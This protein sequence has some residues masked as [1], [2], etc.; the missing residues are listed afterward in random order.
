[1]L[2]FEELA[3]HPMPSPGTTAAKTFP[4]PA[5][6]AG[7]PNTVAM[8][9]F[10]DAPLWPDPTVAANDALGNP[11][12]TM[13]DTCLP[14]VIPTGGV[15]EGRPPGSNFAHQRWNE[16]PPRFYV[17]TAV[18]G[19]RRNSGRLD[20]VQ[21]HGYA[22]GEF[23]PVV[24]GLENQTGL[25][26]NTVVAPG[27]DETTE[28]IE[29]RL[30][31]LLPIQS[32]L[33]VWTFSDGTLPPKLMRVRQ[34]LPLL[35]RNYNALP[36]ATNANA[37]FGEH[38]LST[39]QHNGHNPGESDGFTGAYFF[40]G[41]FYDYRW[42]MQLAGHD[43][44]NTAA[45][46]PRASI[47]C[48]PG[49]TL[50]IE[51]T[52]KTCNTDTLTINIPGDWHE[53][54]STHWF[55][56]HMIDSTAENVYKGIAGM[57]NIYTGIDRGT[58]GFLCNYD[59]PANINLCF[60]SGTALDWG[61][62]DYDVDLLVAD[63]ALDA[64]GQLTFP[65]LNADGFLGDVMAVNWLYKPYFDVRARRYRFR[66]L[67]G[68][69]ARF[70]KIAIVRE[71]DDATSGN[72]P[73]PAGS[74]RS[75]SRV[76]FHMIANDGNIMEHAV[77]FPN[78]ESQDLPV[79]AN[80]ERHDIIVDFREFPAGTKLYLVNTL[81]FDNGRGPKAV[82]PLADILN[83][84]FA[85]AID[86]NNKWTED[87]AVGKFLEFR[88]QPYSGT[89]LSMNPVDYEVGKKMMIPLVRHTNTELAAAIHRTFEFGRSGGTDEKPWTIRTDDGSGLTAD[90]GRVA[91]APEGGAI[92]IWHIINGGNGWAH[93]I[94]IHFEEGQYLL[95]S[96]SSSGMPGN[97]RLPPLWEIGARKDLYVVADLGDPATGG[98][99]LPDVSRSI[100]VAIRF[101]EFMGT[102]VEHCHNTVHED[103]AML[104]RWDNEHPGQTVRIPTP[105]PTW[106]GVSYIATQQLATIKTGN[107]AVAAASDLDSDDVLD[108]AD[109]CVMAANP[110]QQDTGDGGDGVGDA[111]DNCI[112]VA[113]A[114][115]RDTDSDG[116]GN[117]CDADFNQNGVVDST[118]LSDLKTALR[119]TAPDQDLN[120]NGVVDSTDYSIA[121]GYLRQP[122]GPS[123]CGTLSP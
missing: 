92:E 49:E 29:P 37:G 116:Y 105:I 108:S 12:A 32:A 115:Q 111:C 34:G 103:N 64:G 38:T 67:N 107:T 123:C 71:F 2:R 93:P 75:Y 1:M 39:H 82:I 45:T 43:T 14:G 62:R 79:M 48:S 106:D 60:P 86:G 59:D 74:N 28:G 120:G 55:H 22:T 4:A 77:P 16:F 119:S 99:D 51:G 109:N 33:T 57:F 96:D 10:L 72:L 113:N 69:P 9:A 91:A 114:D 110:G 112:N 30:H 6:C 98:L 36:I 97:S 40:P 47:P 101:R 15:I 3:V 63:K 95:R 7:R 104:L 117:A 52:G 18:G 23:G 13:I 121:K 61:N 21:S 53:I 44:I 102:F 76:A 26:H 31:P 19:A 65:P 81:A 11:W 50:V 54:G 83:E 84:T 80:A 122:P 58:E 70:Y 20:T 73:G 17:Q 89:D 68:S 8:D 87:P 35:F 25:Y 27:F 41:E 24:T 46:D 90:P 94:H 42:P 5:T 78:P 88:V 118:D 100:D 66:L 56:D 85:P